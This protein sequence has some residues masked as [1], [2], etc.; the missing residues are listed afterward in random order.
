MKRIHF[1]LLF[2]LVQLS[3]QAQFNRGVQWTEDGNGYRR[4]E[5]KEI[6]Q[7]SLPDLQ[8]TVLIS[9]KQLTPAGKSEPLTVRSYEFSE[10][11][12]KALIYTNTA[13]V[14][15]YDT[16]GD[17]W[18]LDL[19]KNTLTQ[20]GKGRPVSSLMFAKFSPDGKKVA[21]VSERNIFAEDLATGKITPLTKDG[22]TRL[23]NGTFDW[24][25]EE[26][27]DCR[28]GFRWSP[29]SRNIAYW[30]IDATKIRNFLMINNT[31]STYAFN[32]PVE[33]P[34]VG[35]RPSPYKIGVVSASGGATKWM[36][37][38]GDP[39]NTYIPRMEWASANELVLEQL[40]RKQNQAKCLYAD[41]KTGRTTEFYTDSDD[42]W[43]ET[44]S[45]YSW[46]DSPAGW[47]WLNG[48]KEFLWMSEKDGWR[49]LYRVSRDGKTEKCLTVGDYDVIGIVR[50]DEKNNYAYFMA[51]PD[52]ATQTYLFRAKL[53]GSGKAERMSPVSQVGSHRYDISPNG[54]WASHSFSN[55]NTAPMNEWLR[56]PDHKALKESDDIT[57]K[58]A[59][60]TSAKKKVEFFRVKTEDG[61]ELDGWMV[62]PDNFDPAKKYPIVFSVYGE[63]ASSTVMDRWGTGRNGLYIGD[64]AKDG[65]I[66]ASVDNRGTPSPKGRAW[67]KAIYRK[68]GNVNIRDLAMGA[69]TLFAQNA[70]IDTSRVAVHGWSGGGSST[71]NLLFQYPDLFKTGIAVAAVADQLSY[72]NI[73]Q[74]RYMGI[75]QEN[76]EDFVSGSPLSHAKNL[77]ASQN[78]L[79]IHGTGDDNVHYQNAEKLVNEL[80]KYNKQF[81]FMAYPNRSHGIYE[82]EGTSRHL[83]TLFTKFL[84]E[85]CPPGAK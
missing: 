19:D 10:D 73:Y 71:L 57:A 31:D 45:S 70:F 65:Y 1:L 82:G 75:P 49:H 16:R 34:K 72:D 27:F 35:E 3:L 29:D 9:A 76:R 17:Y 23:I 42:A 5:N 78:L 64:M 37:T 74:E 7:Y 26:E 4:I 46:A 77:R 79:Y 84:K 30:Q 33:Y 39:G 44:K 68:I 63:P 41:V 6:I 24:V 36:S 56:L 18:V 66:Y 38:P 2:L 69:K 62:K 83:N 11:G 20:V 58:L 52:N 60:Q 43:V 51:S 53:D 67:R 14:W 15:R 13:R 12:R 80:I 59:A 47:D 22:T 81:Q 61:T 32:V 8:K 21:Y 40:N 50:I 48:G 55:A 85:H 54:A 25:Y 28:D